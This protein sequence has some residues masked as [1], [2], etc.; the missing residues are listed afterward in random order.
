MQNQLNGKLTSASA[1]LLYASVN[2]NGQISS[3]GDLSSGSIANGFGSISTS[4]PITTSDIITA[5]TVGFNIQMSG[6]TGHQDNIN[7]LT[8]RIYI[9]NYK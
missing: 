9:I 3:V 2:G 8:S 7:L 4:N 5:N 1:D 6:S